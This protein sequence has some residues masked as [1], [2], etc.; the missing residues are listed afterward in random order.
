MQLGDRLK[1]LRVNQRIS[2]QELASRLCMNRITYSQYETNRRQPDYETLLKI[3]DYYGVSVDYLL[4]RTNEPMSMNLSLMAESGRYEQKKEIL[5]LIGEMTDAILQNSGRIIGLIHPEQVGTINTFTL[6]G[7]ELRWNGS[8]VREMESR[9]RKVQ[10]Q[11][12][13]PSAVV[14]AGTE[15]GGK[16]GINSDTMVLRRYRI[17][18]AEEIPYRIVDSYYLASLLGELEG[19]DE[20]YTPLLRWLRENKS[21]RASRVHERLKCRLPFHQESY[22]LQIAPIQPVVD[23]ERWVWGVFES[24]KDAGKEVLFEYSRIIANASLHV[25]PYSYEIEEEAFQ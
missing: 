1:K 10:I 4:G 13:Q 18:K 2:Q 22:L 12:I 17:Q 16:L 3:A 14:A 20:T 11:Y 19:K 23:L 5:K 24:G 7:Q 21:L 8:F 9:G 25:F 6:H 15:I